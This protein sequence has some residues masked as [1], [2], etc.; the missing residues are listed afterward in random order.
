[1]KHRLVNAWIGEMDFLRGFAII[2]VI[3]FHTFGTLMHLQF[4]LHMLLPLLFYSVAYLSVPT[5]AFI[6]GFVLMHRYGGSFPV[7]SFYS[8]RAYRIVPPFLFFS[9]FY[10]WINGSI[11]SFS[12]GEILMAFLKVNTGGHLWF[13][14]ALMQ[15]YVAYPLLVRVYA[16]LKKHNKL[17]IFLIS[18]LS[19]QIFY[20]LLFP[21]ESFLMGATLVFYFVLG[22]CCSD[23]YVVIRRTLQNMNSTCLVFPWIVLI[24]VVTLFAIDFWHFS[25][26]EHVYPFS[27]WAYVV[28]LTA[29]LNAISILIIL[30][31]SVLLKKTTMLQKTILELGKYSF[32]MYLIHVFFISILKD[33]LF[34]SG[35]EITLLVVF[36]GATVLNYVSMR[37]LYSVPFFGVIVGK[38]S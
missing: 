1:M 25:F 38:R 4:E 2:A 34:E 10:R 12:L 15:L 11:E 19:F 3:L 35:W 16:F 9:F 7:L 37:I 8:K 5:F 28:I 26:M 33:L 6:S 23:N 32:G 29:L 24:P 20:A 17:E 22:I 18:A 27:P 13:L 31:V 36:F 30:K 21:F 14:F